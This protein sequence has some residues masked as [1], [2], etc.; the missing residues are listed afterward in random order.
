MAAVQ[1]GTSGWRPRS[2]SMPSGARQQAD[3]ADVPGAAFLQPVDRGDGRVGGGQHRL[4]D[5]D[6]ALGDDRPAP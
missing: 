3:E 2:R 6:E 1:I 5:D 4:D